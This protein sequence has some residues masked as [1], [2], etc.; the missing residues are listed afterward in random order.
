MVQF[1]ALLGHLAQRLSKLDGP[2][3]SLCR[4]ARDAGDG[5]CWHVRKWATTTGRG[6][7]DSEVANGVQGRVPFCYPIYIPGGE[8]GHKIVPPEV[9]IMTPKANKSVDIY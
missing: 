5:R 2:E 9:C 7:G 4:A 8:L 6:R 1:P 3:R